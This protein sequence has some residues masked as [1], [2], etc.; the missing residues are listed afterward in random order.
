[1]AGQIPAKLRPQPLLPQQP[2]K[3]LRPPQTAAT[4]STGLIYTSR[5]HSNHH[6]RHHPHC[7]TTVTI[8]T[9]SSSPHISSLSA[10]LPRLHVTT[11]T[12]PSQPPPPM[13]LVGWAHHH[14]VRLAATAYKDVLVYRVSAENGAFGFVAAVGSFGISRKLLRERLVAVIHRLGFEDP[15]LEEEI[16]SFIRDLGHTRVI[17]VLTNINVNYMHQPWRSFAAII[18][19]CLSGK[20]TGLDSLRLSCAQIL[21]EMHCKKNVDYTYLLWEDLDQSISRTNKMFCHTTRDDPMFNTIRVISRNQDSQVYGAIL[22]TELTNQDMLDS[23]AYKEY[24]VIASGG[25]PP[26]AKTK[27]K[28][29]VDESV[30]SPKS[31][32]SSASKGTIL[33][34]KAKVTKHALKKQPTKNTKAK[35]DDD[36]GVRTPSDDE[37]IDEE[38]LDNDETKD[39][40]EDDE[41]LKELYE[42]VN[43]NLE[44]GDAKMT[45]A[46]LKGS[47]QLNVSQELGFE[48][49]EKDAHVTL[50]PVSDAQKADKP[51]QSSSVSSDFTSKFLN[52]ENPSPA[53]NEIASLMETSAPHAT[54]IPKLTSDFTTTTPPPLSCFQDKRSSECGCSMANK[55]AQRRSSSQES[56]LP[57][58]DKDED[59]F[60]GSDRGT[61]RRKSGKVASSSK[62]SRSKE[63]KSSST[64]K[65]ASQSQHKSSGKSVYVEELS[66]TVEESSIQQDQEF[67]TED[68]IEQPVDKEG[69]KAEWFKKPEQPLIPDTDWS[70]RYL[71]YL[72]GRD[73][74][75]RYS[76][77]V[78]KK[79]AATYELKWIK[80]LVSELWSPVVVQYD[81]HAYYG[82]SRKR[83]IAVTILK[84][85]MY[86]YGH[87]EE[88][89]VRRDDLQLHTFKERDF[90]RLRRQDIKYMLLLLIQQKLT[91]LT[92]DERRKRLMSTDELHKFRDGTLND[93]RS[94]LHDI[95]A[96]I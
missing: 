80:D 32:T 68:N 43:V 56:R 41:V 72:K 12:T 47:K 33:K 54:T 35:E 77:S 65:D 81:Q 15:P 6:S 90:K 3:H 17:K 82:T 73:S 86:D 18:N 23:K 26:K 37:F 45:D 25:E 70:K 79:T 62:D 95:A 46:N 71:E 60:A 36:K 38:K 75:R 9:P 29:K 87:L 13:P 31:K 91:N 69:T 76:T 39:D 14:R 96:G 20:T 58:L 61:K 24:Y 67:V 94:A 4:P 7:H 64:S 8:S 84:I 59:P 88:I 93:V 52:L 53:D 89:K 83:I 49:E 48:Q 22:P 5:H 57:Q 40:E 11:T 50:T 63:K 55:Q 85:K 42:D 2:P 16:L 28:K 74:S 78:T 27:Y 1:V 66:H 21:W 30:I 51:V 19:K 44:N 92:I 10:S 34:S